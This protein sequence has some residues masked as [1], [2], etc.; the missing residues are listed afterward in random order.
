M[1]HFHL[2]IS[3]LLFDAGHCAIRQNVRKDVGNATVPTES[4]YISAAGC[5][6]APRRRLHLRPDIGKDN[7]QGPSLSSFLRKQ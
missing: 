5:G 4:R 6:N 7:F 3:R 2:L 1:G